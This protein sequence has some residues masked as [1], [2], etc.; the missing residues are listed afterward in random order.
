MSLQST[1]SKKLVLVCPP[2]FVPTSPPAGIAMLKAYAENCQ[3]E[4]QVLLKDLNLWA[5]DSCFEALHNGQIIPNDAFY[6]DRNL[7]REALFESFRAFKGQINSPAFFEDPD[8]YNLM[9]EGLLYFTEFCRNSMQSECIAFLEKGRVYPFLSRMI[10]KLEVR[11]ADA[12]GISVSFPQ[13]LIAAAAIGKYVREK[14][15][16][17]V[18]FGGG[19]FTDRSVEHFAEWY[20]LSFDMIVTGEG[21]DALLSLLDNG[22]EPRDIPNVIYRENGY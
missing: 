4:W 1:A 2:L 14:Y 12:L 13:Q 6:S 18:V 22:F 16:I 5:F 9:G 3:Q 11:G 19:Y 17:P 7:S 8:L 20:P 10:A 21:E 15:Q